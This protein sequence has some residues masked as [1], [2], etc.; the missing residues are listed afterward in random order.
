MKNTAKYQCKHILIQAQPLIKHEERQGVLKEV[1][2]R[3]INE[4]RRK[5]VLNGK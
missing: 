5:D 4:N 3:D 2:N 1:R